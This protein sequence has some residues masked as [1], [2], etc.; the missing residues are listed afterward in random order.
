[1]DARLAGLEQRTTNVVVNQGD[2]SVQTPAQ[3]FE[4]R[5][6]VPAQPAPIVNVETAP[7]QVR[8]INEVPAAAP[9]IVNVETAPAQ[10]RVLNEVAAPVVNV[11]APDREEIT[12][13]QRD[14]AGRITRTVKTHKK[15][16]P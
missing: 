1:M 14:K 10:V 6:E 7:A 2:T 13:V 11:H 8:V 16:K 9:P 5:N 3:T 15:A 12:D 4:I